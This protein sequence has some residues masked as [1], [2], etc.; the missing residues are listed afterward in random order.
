MARWFS[1]IPLPFRFTNGRTRGRPS[2]AEAPASPAAVERPAAKKAARPAESVNAVAEI[3][4]LVKPHRKVLAVVLTCLILLACLNLALPKV[5]KYVIDNVFQGE[6]AQAVRASRLLWVLPVVFVI[7]VLRNALFYFSKTRVTEVGEETAFEVRESLFR[8]LH[9]LSVDFYQRSNPGKISARVMQDVQ[10]IKAFIQDELAN[11]IL[12]LLTLVVVAVILLTSNVPL[13][14]L[15]MAVMPFDV[16]V[17]YVFRKPISTYARQAKEQIADVSGDLVQQFDASGAVTV[18][19]SA[20]QLLEQEKF[21][22]SMRKGMRAQIR[23]SKYYVLQKVAAEMLVGVGT[24]ILF[25]YGGYA[26]INGRMTSGD[27]VAFYVYVRMLYPCLLSLVSQSGKFAHTATSIERVAQ[28]LQITP[29]VQ[30]KSDAI[31]YEITQGKIEFQN[32]SFAYQNGSSGRILNKVSFD[33]GPKEHV[34]ITGPSGG[35]KSTSVN[36]IARFY[37]P[38]GGRI[39]IDGVDVRDFT[40]TSL[41]RQIGF[42]FQDCFL[43]NDTVMANIRYAWPGAN[44]EAVV[45]AS[46]RSFAH[47]FIEKLPNGYETVIGEGGVQLSAGQKRRLMIA[48]AFLKNPKILILDE[49]LV[50]L[51]SEA[52]KRAIEGLSS[53][54][55]SRTVLT[56]TH[57][58]AEIPHV[59]KQVHICDGRVTVRD[60]SG[61]ILQSS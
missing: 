4:R 40:L 25:A 12:N 52:R 13:A 55:G 2:V 15:T 42:V 37:D 9:T 56:I 20:T 59:T 61:R 16:L 31:P 45:E 32:V 27:F 21:R 47:E 26:V 5:L 28:I 8:H 24:I 50:S 58:P 3:Y 18:K 17:Y 7:Y 48:R 1:L 57:Y 11:F 60:L 53:L 14:L 43:F 29:G 10:A 36:L 54:I 19:A 23:Q 44:D 39:L 38:E 41:R 6:E 22:H 49:P 51:D 35:G 33:I 30:E 34:L 46:R